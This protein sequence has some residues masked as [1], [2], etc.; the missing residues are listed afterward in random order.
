MRS[1]VAPMP[2]GQP[3]AEGP[4]W[5]G[6]F[7]LGVL[8]TVWSTTYLAIKVAV[9]PGGFPPFLMSGARILAAGAMLGL[10]A[11]VLRRPLRVSKRDFGVIL[12]AG[13]LLWIGGNGAVT[14]AEQ[15]ADSNYAALLVGALPI[16][17]ALIEAI[18]DRKLPS[19]RLAL[20]LALGFSGVAL[21]VLPELLAA[22]GADTASV[23]ALL[24][25][26]IS[27]GMGTVLQARAKPKAAPLTSAALQQL[28]GGVVFLLIA[29]AVGERMPAQAAPEA[30]WA[31]AYLVVFGGLAFLSF[32]QAVQHLPTR[33]VMTYAYVNPVGA[34]FLGWWLLGE[35]IT[36][37]TAAGAALVLLGV[38]GVFRERYGRAI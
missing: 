25:A 1:M 10:I 31:W 37:I 26:P 9:R 32:V 23:L 20:A 30:W 17:V 3:E 15:Q 6:L 16:W 35:Q 11:L 8:Y 27:W 33:V 7:H 36:W 29:A 28:A 38:A 5:V 18:V 13:L 24:F 12:A 21:L 14:W 19:G 2:A 22:E 34:A 4:A